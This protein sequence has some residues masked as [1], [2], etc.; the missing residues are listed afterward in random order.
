MVT[1]SVVKCVKRLICVLRWRNVKNVCR[2]KWNVKAVPTLVRYQRV[3]G[4]VKE[5]GRLVEGELLDQEKL[6][7]FTGAHE[8]SVI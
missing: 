3:E 6:K 1:S 7:I 2:T 8:K 5:T 4:N